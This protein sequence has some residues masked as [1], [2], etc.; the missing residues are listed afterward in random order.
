MQFQ[1]SKYIATKEKIQF[2]SKMKRKFPNHTRV[3]L[4][5]VNDVNDRVVNDEV[6]KRM[7][8]FHKTFT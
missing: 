2:L 7:L 8:S 3:V 4:I 5:V 6:Q 1:C